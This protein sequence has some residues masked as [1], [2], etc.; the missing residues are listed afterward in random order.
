M[1]LGGAC[2]GYRSKRLTQSRI[3]LTSIL[4]PVAQRRSRY[5][6]F[7][8][9]D[10]DYLFRTRHPRTRPVD[11]TVDPDINWI[12]LEVIDTVAGG[13]D[14]RLRR[15]RIHCSVRFRG[16]QTQPARAQPLRA[17]GRWL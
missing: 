4:L 3:G 5:S 14:R 6:A 8:Y 11:V 10:A 7:A 17:P 16:P 13:P 1:H 12:G 9:A 15:S 2:C